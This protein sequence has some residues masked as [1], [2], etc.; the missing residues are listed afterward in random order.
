MPL[1][2]LTKGLALLMQLYVSFQV[3]LYV[4]LMNLHCRNVQL[5]QEVTVVSTV[6][7]L[8]INCLHQFN[9]MLKKFSYGVYL[10][11]LHYETALL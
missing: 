6:L 9:L 11:Y 8:F 4:S 2:W 10:C 3:L 1:A 7:F 5:H